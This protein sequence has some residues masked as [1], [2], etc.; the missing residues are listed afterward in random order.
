MK[1]IKRIILFRFHENFDICRNHLQIIKKF[2]PGIE[3]YGL[4]GGAEKNFQKAKQLPL[5]YIWNIPMDDPHW[6]W[7]NGDLC[8]RWWFKDFGQKI[9]FDILHVFEWDLVLL[10]SVENQFP[11]I[12]GGVA[13]TGVKPM[14]KIYDTWDWV[15]PKRGRNEWLRLEGFV[16]KHYHYQE[17]PL[18]GI[19]G[20]ASFSKIFLEKYSKVEIPGWCNDEVR[21]PLFAQAFN[22]PVYDT[23]LR[24]KFFTAA[25]DKT[26]SPSI[27][28]QQYTK[29]IKSFHPVKDLLDLDKIAEIKKLNRNFNTPKKTG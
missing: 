27:V 17:K 7:V 14:A 9:G 19:F 10:E 22:L 23:N 25:G 20:G 26:F 29:G 24:S 2:N 3:I 21:T 12:K 1:N 13:I 18:A 6:K 16:K 4:Y 11:H 15:A 8:I 28:Y 5:E